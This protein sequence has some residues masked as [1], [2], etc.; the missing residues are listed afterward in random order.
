VDQE[1]NPRPRAREL[2]RLLVPDWR[3]TPRQVLWT[4][5]IAIVLGGLIAI[6]YPYDITL[7]DW[8]NLLIVPAVI[9]AGGVWFNQQQ[10]KREIALAEQRAQDEALQAYLDQMSKLLLEE[11]LHNPDPDSEFKIGEVKLNEAEILARARTL[12]VL[13]RLDP[14]RKAKV[15]QFLVEAALVQNL[16]DRGRPVIRLVGADLQEAPLGSYDLHVISLDGA[17]LSN[18]DLSNAD[19]SNATLTWADLE[20]A[21]LRG[22]RLFTANLRDAN[23]EQADLSDARGW[24]DEQ[25]S[26]AR[27]LKEATMPN[28]QKY[29]AWLRSKGSREDGENGGPSMS[30]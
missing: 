15:L 1:Q 9:A 21:N 22:A 18:A 20:Q 3:P 19:L 7:W 16:P 5:G 2:V 26:A 12:T 17:D 28:G 13:R 25:L 4:I 30:R 8:A 6:G 27:S 23:L 10:R 14:N 29:E 24:T 11:N